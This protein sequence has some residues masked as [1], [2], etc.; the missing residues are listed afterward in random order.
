MGT[1]AC[2]GGVSGQKRWYCD[3]A[4]VRPKNKTITYFLMLCRAYQK[5]ED[6]QEAEREKQPTIQSGG[7]RL[8]SLNEL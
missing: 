7:K 1:N 2:E 6:E 4:A 8:N 5:I 3:N